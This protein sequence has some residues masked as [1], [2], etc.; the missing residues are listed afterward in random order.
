MGVVTATATELRADWCVYS[1][2]QVRLLVILMQNAEKKEERRERK[3][4]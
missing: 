2:L 1:V 3:R 4:R